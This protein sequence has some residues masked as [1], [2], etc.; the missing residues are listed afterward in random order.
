MSSSATSSP[1]P[2]PTTPSALSSPPTPL[3][4][5]SSRYPNSKMKPSKEQIDSPSRT[6]V[7]SRKVESYDS[8]FE[9]IQKAIAGGVVPAFS[10]SGTGKDP[11]EESMN[12]APM[13]SS[14][15]ARDGDL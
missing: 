7:G 2:R 14:A 6:G 4:R 8:D 11:M 15:S 9:L 1:A 10:S 12:H 5:S 13:I 3:P